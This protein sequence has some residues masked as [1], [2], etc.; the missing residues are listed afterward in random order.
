MDPYLERRC[1]WRGFQA[2]LIVRI[3]NL[4]QPQMNSEFVAR[5][6]ERGVGYLDPSPDECHRYIAIRRPRQLQ[7]VTVI[8]VVSPWHKS[9]DGL[10]KYR[11]AQRE[12][13]GSGANLAGDR[14]PPLR[15][16]CNRVSGA[17]SHGS[18]L[19][20]LRPS[21]RHPRVG[22]DSVWPAGPAAGDPNSGGARHRRSDRR[23]P[24]P[25]HR[26]L[27]R[28]PVW[29]RRRLLGAAGDARVAGTMGVVSPIVA[30][31]GY[32]SR[33]RLKGSQAR[34]CYLGEVPTSQ[35][36]TRRHGYPIPLFLWPVEH[37]RGR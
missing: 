10:R 7:D 16:P 15:E 33:S 11:E 14:S 18:A 35:R 2:W 13:I 28:W 6:L 23:S 1:T 34:A 32:S 24:I 31:E 17:A 3:C 12:V 4:L 25:V 26:L 36:S 5:N 37:P 8:E 22:G 21:C 27:R 20:Y 19:R 9:G 29:S 30:G